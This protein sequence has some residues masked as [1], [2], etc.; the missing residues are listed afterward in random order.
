MTSSVILTSSST[1]G[2]TRSI[3]GGENGSLGLI[4][5]HTTTSYTYTTTTTT[6]SAID[7]GDNFELI[8][9]VLTMTTL[10]IL[11]FGLGCSVQLDVIKKFIVRPKQFV[12][13]IILQL[14]LMR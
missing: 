5:N 7:D 12:T 4:E 2:L 14:F 1:P 10:A 13:G 3:L 9:R 6:A 8:T 11:M